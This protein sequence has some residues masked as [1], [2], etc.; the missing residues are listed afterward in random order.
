[1]AKDLLKKPYHRVVSGTPEDG[2]FGEA[3]ELPGCYTVGDTLQEALANLEEA[4]AL[5]LECQILA[6]DPIPEPMTLVLA[7]PV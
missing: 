4:M 6:G 5:W 1:M 3:P 2:Y 7:S